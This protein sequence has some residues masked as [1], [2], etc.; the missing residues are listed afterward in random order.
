[1]YRGSVIQTSSFIVTYAFAHFVID[2][3]CAF[4]LLGVLAVDDHAVTAMI[5]YN[6]SAFVLQAPLGFVIDKVFNPKAASVL[7]L[8][9]V[10]LSFLFWNNIFVALLMA[11]IGNALFHV[12]GGSLV[13]SIKSKTATWAGLFIAPGGIGLATGS[14]LAFSQTY[15]SLM[16]LPLTLILLALLLYFV[17]TPNFERTNTSESLPNLGILI[18]ALL[19]IPIVVRS[20]TGLSVE[21]PWKENRLLLWLLVAAIATGK[22]TGGVLADKYGL[23]KVG[24]GGFIVA[25]ALLAF[26]PTIPT[27]GIFG[28][29]TLNLTVT[30]TL[31]AIVKV[32]PQYKGL[33]FGLTTTALFL[34]AIPALT[35]H[36]FFK[37]EW[38][39]FLLMLTASIILLIALCTKRFKNGL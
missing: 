34:G 7:G 27:L 22:V 26:F 1:M 18:V 14:L 12:G 8:I 31:I 10:A 32:M 37:N 2:A 6:A 35:S 3:A 11:G 19:L 23:K 36:Y 9:F 30:V 17:Q 28:A 39:V 4:L 24:F 25:A 5:I 29:L 21:F 33:A 20:L 38:F 13:L 15:I 16:L